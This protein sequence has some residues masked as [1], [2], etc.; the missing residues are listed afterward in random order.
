MQK[1]PIDLGEIHEVFIGRNEMPGY[2]CPEI[3]CLALNGYIETIDEKG[4]KRVVYLEC[5]HGGSCNR[6]CIILP[7]MLEFEYNEGTKTTVH[8]GGGKG[9]MMDDILE[10]FQESALREIRIPIRT[11]PD[12]ETTFPANVKKAFVVFKELGMFDTELEPEVIA[13][14]KSGERVEKY[15]LTVKKIGEPGERSKKDK[16]VKAFKTFKSFF[17]AIER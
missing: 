8:R 7:A 10:D 6:S 11:N 4:S 17:G 15:V 3:E 12:D 2:T 5:V 16:I 13:K 1:L 14:I 9:Q